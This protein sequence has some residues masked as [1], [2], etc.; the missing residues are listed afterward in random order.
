MFPEGVRANNKIKGRH[1]NSKN[2]ELTKL[3]RQRVVLKNKF[4]RSRFNGRTLA[5]LDRIQDKIRSKQR[6]IRENCVEI[7]TSIGKR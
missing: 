2:R 6:K 7:E 5:D 3:I 1:W 4:M